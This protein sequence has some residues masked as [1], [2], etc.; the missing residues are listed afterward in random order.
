MVRLTYGQVTS[1]ELLKCNVPL[2]TRMAMKRYDS[3]PMINDP[4]II[5]FDVMTDSTE[6]FKTCLNIQSRQMV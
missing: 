6:I 5:D 2:R 1:Y 3:L 4:A